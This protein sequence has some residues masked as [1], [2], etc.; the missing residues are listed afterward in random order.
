MNN[1]RILA[2]IACTQVLAKLSDYFDGELAPEVSAQI[3]AH[4]RQ[5]DNCARFGGAFTAIVAGLRKSIE[6][7]SSSASAATARLRSRLGLRD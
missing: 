1:D 6:A 7:P 3:E 4:V 5:C 2:G